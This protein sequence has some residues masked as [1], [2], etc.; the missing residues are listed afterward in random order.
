MDKYTVK[1]E[2]E[3]H[4]LRQKHITASE[5]AVL[6]GLNPYSSPGKLK[7]KDNTFIGN[8]NTIIGQVLEPVV[9][10]ITNRVLKTSFQLFEEVK[11]EKVF[12]TKG[13]LGATPD[14]K[15]DTMLLECKTTRPDLLIKYSEAPP[16][17]YLVQLQVQL[18]CTNI[19]TGYLAI[20]GTDLSQPGHK[21]KPEFPLVI[22]EV[23]RDDTLCT[24]IEQEA[25]RFFEAREK[26]ENF[27]VSSTIKKQCATLLTYKKIFPP[28]EEMSALRSLLC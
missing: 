2:E 15:D 5:A 22:F 4:S 28:K 23:Q 25:N 11:D 14:A 1:T 21:L 17:T 13:P 12:F 19:K 7:N 26:E 10:D 20:L 27:R 9:V 6:V 24:L 16:T 3:W 8:A 18:W